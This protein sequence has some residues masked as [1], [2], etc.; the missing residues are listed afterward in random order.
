MSCYVRRCELFFNTVRRFDLIQVFKY[1][2]ASEFTTNEHIIPATLRLCIS[3]ERSFLEHRQQLFISVLYLL[4]LAH[5]L[6]SF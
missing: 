4:S 3:Q 2:L 1:F 5:T 6:A